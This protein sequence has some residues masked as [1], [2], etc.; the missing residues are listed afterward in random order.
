VIREV[1]G[2]EEPQ[3]LWHLSGEIELAGTQGN[4]NWTAVLYVRP[5]LET[6]LDRIAFGWAE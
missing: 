6:V 3:K 4:K 2:Q 1:E 5:F